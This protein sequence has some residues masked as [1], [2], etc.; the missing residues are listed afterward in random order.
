M[1]VLM[2]YACRTV[3]PCLKDVQTVREEK[4]TMKRPKNRAPSK[5]REGKVLRV[6]L[7]G[8]CLPRNQA[9]LNFWETRLLTV[10]KAKEGNSTWE[11]QEYKGKP[12]VIEEFFC[13]SDRQ[14]LTGARDA[15]WIIAAWQDIGC[16]SKREGGTGVLC[17]GSFPPVDHRKTAERKESIIRWK[18]RL[19]FELL[20]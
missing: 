10:R 14:S 20:S 12:H 17:L 7:S 6:L 15:W 18:L 2:C 9:W 1:S 8:R 4:K 16:D 3:L 19:V 13:G 5:K 11:H